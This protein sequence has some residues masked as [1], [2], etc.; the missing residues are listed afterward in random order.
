MNCKV[1]HKSNAAG[2]I[3]SWEREVLIEDGGRDVGKC[4]APKQDSAEG[5][6]LTRPASPGWESR[7]FTSAP[8]KVCLWG[9]CSSE[10][11]PC[12]LCKVLRGSLDR[13]GASY[14]HFMPYDGEWEHRK[15]ACPVCQDL[16][17]SPHWLH[18]LD[19]K[20][21]REWVSPWSWMEKSILESCNSLL[22]KWNS[23]G[24]SAWGRTG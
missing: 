12:L 6:A 14:I 16:E 18:L 4:S 21:P 15:H 3:W 5:P 24:G 8:R 17:T 2:W 1:L 9:C 13:G 23:S 20:R 11:V 19:T 7:G 10:P 22:G